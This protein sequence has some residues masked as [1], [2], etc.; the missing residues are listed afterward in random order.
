MRGKGLSSGEGQRKGASVSV[1]P[2]ECQLVRKQGLTQQ[3]QVSIIPAA[4][5]GLIPAL[6]N[7]QAHDLATIRREWVDVKGR[8][9]VPGSRLRAC[10][11]IDH[12]RF[13][14]SCYCVNNQQLV[15][16]STQGLVK[17]MMLPI[18]SVHACP[19]HALQMRIRYTPKTTRSY[20]HCTT[21]ASH[22]PPRA[23]EGSALI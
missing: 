2:H 11:K 17:S 5:L 7:G 23:F 18:H 1:R 9:V 21:C 8:Q 15:V 4:L 12:V 3:P 22:P 13:E 19:S 6:T 20:M 14:E 16:Q 10:R